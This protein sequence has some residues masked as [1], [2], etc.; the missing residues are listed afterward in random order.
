MSIRFDISAGEFFDLIRPAALIL[1]AIISTWVFASARKHAFSNLV[2]ACWALGVFAF[3]PIVLPIYLVKLLF[4]RP[5]PVAPVRLRFALPTLYLLTLVSSVCLYLYQSS[6]TVD[7]HLARATL[8]KL[9]GGQNLTIAEYRRALALE[10]NPHTHKRLAIELMEAGYLTEAISEFRLAEKGG[11]PDDSIAF[12][13]GALFEMLNYFGQ[14]RLEYE[15]YLHSAAC[16]QS[17]PDARCEIAR[18][19]AGTILGT[20]GASY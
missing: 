1:S 17:N 11:E 8:A 4:A 3:P 7:A 19:R 9:A 12:R 2:S 18:A 16:T 20:S 13:L 15:R 14:A 5:V 10:D 6:R